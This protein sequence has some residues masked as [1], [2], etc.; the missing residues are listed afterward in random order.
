MLYFYSFL[1]VSTFLIV[2]PLL[3]FAGCFLCYSVQYIYACY[4]A[5]MFQIG[6]LKL[7]AQICLVMDLV[8][9]L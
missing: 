8:L 2:K 4:M 6:N 7:Q 5:F 1:S 9:K 3:Y